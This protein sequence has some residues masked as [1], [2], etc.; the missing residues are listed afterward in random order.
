MRLSGERLGDLSLFMLRDRCAAPESAPFTV[1]WGAR[2]PV[3]DG[4]RSSCRNVR[5]YI[6][7][8]LRSLGRAF[9]LGTSSRL[10]ALELY[11]SQRGRRPVGTHQAALVPGTI[12]GTRPLC[13]T[14]R[15]CGQEVT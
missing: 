7:P 3:D 10:L 4:V 13:G 8:F 6:G 9:V 2:T 12:P 14:V 1:S 11:V 5:A 15:L